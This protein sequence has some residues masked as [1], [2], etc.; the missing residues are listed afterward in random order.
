M[1]IGL[2]TGVITRIFTY[3]KIP[4]A[5]HLITISKALGKSID[6]LLTGEEP[7]GTKPLKD[8][9]G[10]HE[11]ALPEKHREMVAKLIEILDGSNRSN[12]VS[13]EQNVNAFHQ[14]KDIQ[15]PGEEEVDKDTSNGGELKKNRRS[16]ER[17]SQTG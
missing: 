3:D 7:S 16:K 4:T 5:K 1:S 15:I 11:Y 12:A 9:A 8:A 10:V 6:W 17:R 13:I 14:T 2:D